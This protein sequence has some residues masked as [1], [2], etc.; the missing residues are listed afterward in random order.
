MPCFC[1]HSAT[2]IIMVYVNLCIDKGE[3]T[4]L[5]KSWK[6][7]DYWVQFSEII[8]SGHRGDEPRMPH[9]PA[10]RSQ[11]GLTRKGDKARMSN[12]QRHSF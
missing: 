12:Q 5:R 11:G 7:N 1:Y 2:T 9:Q 6:R 3:H 4:V 8:Q 10:K